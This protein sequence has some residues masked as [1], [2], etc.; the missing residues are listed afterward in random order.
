M[1][2]K[3]GAFN[4]SLRTVHEREKEF[5]LDAMRAELI[6]RGRSI[7]NPTAYPPPGRTPITD[8]IE[9]AD[10]VLLTDVIIKDTNGR[11]GRTMAIIDNDEEYSVI[12]QDVVRALNLRPDRRTV[13][14]ELESHF[15]EPEK[16]TLQLFY[17]RLIIECEATIVDYLPGDVLIIGVKNMYK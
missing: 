8:D 7:Y 13:Q 11:M 9:A 16:I 15:V 12:S 17:S 10:S 1:A 5:D 2:E 4:A 6:R 3:S 14:V